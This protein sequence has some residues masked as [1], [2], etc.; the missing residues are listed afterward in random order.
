MSYTS[1]VDVAGD[2]FEVDDG[3]NLAA[4]V[5]VVFAGFPTAWQKN[6]RC[7]RFPSVDSA[8]RPM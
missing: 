3:A 5:L 1:N 8:G 6:A 2:G 7:A 4:A